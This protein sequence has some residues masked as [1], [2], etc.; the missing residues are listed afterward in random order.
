MSDRPV[1]YASADRVA[2]ITLNRPESLNAID[3]QLPGALRAAVERA[4]ADPAV[5]VIVLQ[6]AGKGFCGGYDLKV[7]CGDAG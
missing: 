2:T 5:H 6:G 3:A 7:V 1:R 4:D